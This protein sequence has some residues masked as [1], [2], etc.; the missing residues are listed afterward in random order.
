MNK[1]HSYKGGR[2]CVTRDLQGLQ[3]SRYS[4]VLDVE[5]AGALAVESASN[6]QQSRA[7][8]AD[9]TDSGFYF[10]ELPPIEEQFNKGTPAGAFIVRGDQMAI[11][12]I[13]SERMANRGVLRSIWLAHQWLDAK[14]W[15]MRHALKR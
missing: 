8:L 7:I 5:T 9:F 11:A 4:G 12:A 3:V 6:V 10:D 2:L 13:Y 14:E 1:L 15:V